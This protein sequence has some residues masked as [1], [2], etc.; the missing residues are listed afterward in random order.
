MWFFSIHAVSVRISKYN[1]AYKIL[2]YVS[3][4]LNAKLQLCNNDPPPT[5]V[6]FFFKLK[7]LSISSFPKPANS[8]WQ[9]QNKE[10]HE[11]DPGCFDSFLLSCS[12]CFWLYPV[13]M[14]AYHR[15]RSNSTWKLLPVFVYLWQHNLVII[16]LSRIR[17]KNLVQ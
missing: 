11:V 1:S 10:I 14:Y 7:L 12:D 13:M 9:K 3:N 2:A 16:C 4:N 15:H 5:L 8:L 17:Y 6:H